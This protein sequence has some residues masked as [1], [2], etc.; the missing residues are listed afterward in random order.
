MPTDPR[1]ARY[2]VLTVEQVRYGLGATAR[3]MPNEVEK[4]ERDAREGAE[5]T[6]RLW[7]AWLAFL[8]LG[9]IY[10]LVSQR[11][12]IGPSWALLVVLVITLTGGALLRRRGWMR[13]NRVLVLCGLMIATAAVS[14]SAVFLLSTLLSHSTG[15]E[16]LLRDAALLWTSNVLTFGLWYWETDAGGPSRRHARGAGSTDFAFPQTVIPQKPARPWMPDFLDYLFLAFNT[17]TAFSPTDTLVLARRAKILMMYQSLIS[18]VTIAV[19]A[20]RAINT[21]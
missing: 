6:V 4:V 1:N 20:A 5:E 11:L 16:D 19:L 10:A 13:V 7:P 9:V 8:A 21:L 3:G 2:G 18:L 12:T 14:V 15:A 17:S